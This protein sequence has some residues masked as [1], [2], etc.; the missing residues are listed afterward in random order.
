MDAD[1]TTTAND[2]GKP[3]TGTASTNPG[4]VQQHTGQ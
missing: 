3:A 1:G 2:A 4:I